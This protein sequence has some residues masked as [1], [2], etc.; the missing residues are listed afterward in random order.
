MQAVRLAGLRRIAGV[1][2]LVLG[3]GLALVGCQAT[4]GTAAYV[5]DS[6]FTD[7]QVDQM[8]DQID[9]DVLKVQ[10]EQNGKIDFGN[11]R[12]LLVRLQV[13]DALAARY[14]QE[15]HI[16]VPARDYAAAAQQ[17]GLPADD[18]YVRLSTDA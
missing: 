17:I 18:P 11:L 14:A 3:A 10:P 6:R 5:G 1:T 4:P 7:N 12:Q 9:A 8:V 16:D 13:F 2:A 15:Q